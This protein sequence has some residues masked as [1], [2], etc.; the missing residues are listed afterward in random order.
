M[1]EIVYHANYQNEDSYWWFVARNNI[2]L[3]I[4]AND[5]IVLV[6]FIIFEILL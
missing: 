4:F 1:Q 2:V 6:G 3:E 5:I